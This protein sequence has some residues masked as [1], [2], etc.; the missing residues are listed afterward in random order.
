MQEVRGSIPLG[1]T[2]H[3]L[4]SRI[5]SQS[6]ECFDVLMRHAAE[7]SPNTVTSGARCLSD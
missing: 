6:G 4:Q 2:K 1:S 3:S 7:L 5:I